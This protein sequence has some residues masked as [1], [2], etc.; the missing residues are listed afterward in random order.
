MSSIHSY[1]QPMPA[2]VLY[3]AIADLSGLL[4]DAA[5]VAISGTAA[6]A[7]GYAT[8]IGTIY[9]DMGKAVKGA[10]A[11]PGTFRKVQMVP[12]AASTAVGGTDAD[13]FLTCYIKLGVDGKAGATP[14]ARMQ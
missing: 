3:Y 11:T 7:A 13:N 14:V 6:T 1:I 9:R 2:N 12:A 4:Y 8:V 5:G 10:T